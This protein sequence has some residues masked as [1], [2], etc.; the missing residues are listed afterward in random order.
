M[1]YQEGASGCGDHDDG[2]GSAR[3]SPALLYQK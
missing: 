2:Y 3:K 1:D